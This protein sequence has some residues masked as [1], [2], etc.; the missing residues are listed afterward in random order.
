MKHSTVSSPDFF[1]PSPNTTS[2]SNAPAAALALRTAAVTA[3]FAAVVTL[4]ALAP[5][6]GQS[7]FDRTEGRTSSGSGLSV[8]VFADIEDAQLQKNR[9]TTYE[10][11]D[12]TRTTVYVPIENPVDYLGTQGSHRKMADTAYLANG[13]VSPQHTFFNNTLYVSNDPEA[14]NTLLITVDSSSIADPGGDCAIAEVR[15]GRAGETIT[16]QVPLTSA[17]GPTNGPMATYYQAFVRVLDSRA[18]NDDGTPKYALSDG[19]GCV[20]D[21]ND[22]DDV[23]FDVAT[24]IAQDETAS[25]LARHND[26]VTVSMSGAGTVSVRVDGEGPELLDVTPEDLGYYRSRDLEY[27]FTVRDD[28]AGLRHDGELVVTLDGDYTQA[29]RDDDHT[30]SGEPLSMPSGSQVSVNGNAAEIDVMVWAKDAHVDTAED[31]THTG[32]WT[33]LGSRPGVA[34][35]FSADGGSMDEGP[36]YME[37]TARDRAGNTTVSDALDDDGQQPH[38]FTVDDTEPKAA[39]AWTGIAYDLEFPMG[40]KEVPDRS[41]IMVDFVE[42][43]RRDIRPEL[44]RVAGHEVVSVLQPTEVPPAERTVLGRDGANSAPAG[45]QRLTFAPPAPR[46]ATLLAPRAQSCS[47]TLDEKV[48]IGSPGF[49]YDSTSGDITISWTRLS[50]ADCHGYRLAVLTHDRA[51]LIEDLPRT[52]ESFSIPRGSE[53]GRVIEADIRDSDEEQLIIQIALRHGSVE[54]GTDNFGKRGS[55]ATVDLND[56]TAPEDALPLSAPVIAPY[57]LHPSSSPAVLPAIAEGDASLECGFTDS[58]PAWDKVSPAYIHRP[59]EVDGWTLVGYY[60]QLFYTPN[61]EFDLGRHFQYT[62]IGVDGWKTSSEFQHYYNSSPAVY[63]ARAQI[64]TVYEK[65]GRRLAGAVR[66]VWCSATSVENPQTDSTPPLL[67]TAE[68]DG[69]TLTLTYNEQLDGDSTPD[70]SAFDVQVDGTKNTVNRVSVSGRTVELTL[71]STVTDGQGVT[72]SYE[73]P[74]SNPIQ[75]AAGND[76]TDFLLYPV[77]EALVS[78]LSIGS[79]NGDGNTPNSDADDNEAHLKALM[80]LGYWPIDINGDLIDDVRARIY[81]QVARELRADETPEVLL[82]GGG[83]HDLAGN[84]NPSQNVPTRD[85]IAPRFTITVTATAQD[86][87]VANHLGEFVVDVRA[88][89]DLRRR[90]EV[91][92]TG[93]DTTTV[94]RSG[95]EAYDYSI[96]NIERGGTLVVQDGPQHWSRTYAVASLSGLD[97][98]FGLV[99]Y[100]YDYEGNIGESGGWEAVR[101]QRKP[102]VVTTPALNDK[103]DLGEM[104]DAGALLEIDRR[105]NGGIEPE[106][107]MTPHQ[108]EKPHDTESVRPYVHLN[109]HGEAMEYAVCPTDGCGAANDNPDAKF[110]DSHANVNVTEIMLD[111]GSMMARL[112]RVGPMEFAFQTEELELGRHEVAYKAVDDAGNEFSG[113]YAFTVVERLPYELELTAGWNLI[114]VPGTPEDPSLDT[115]LPPE[116]R[117]SPVLSYQDGDWVAATRSEDGGWRG[118]LTSIEAGYGYWVFAQTF[119]TISTL[120]PEYD[121]ASIPPSVEV[122]FG[123]NLV[124][125]IDLFQNPAGVAPGAYGGGSGEADEYFKSIP[126]QVSYTYDTLQSRWVRTTEGDGDAI[127]DVE[128]DD[129]PPE[130]VTGKGYWVWSLEPAT[131]VP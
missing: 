81:V 124:G 71:S 95:D 53:L 99:V 3:A 38:L 123:W 49:S 97:E 21:P 58:D 17:T 117:V 32:R 82:F 85:G 28:D 92:F 113:D 6:F 127:S 51:L 16:V 91:H 74:S 1:N 59:A 107:S 14:Y 90:P 48:R 80:M 27:A 100:G 40:G 104:D 88:D 55:S 44:V 121:P 101:H 4:L 39:E 72:L 15:N 33:L 31:V 69:A 54:A 10:E 119:E 25:I 65:N 20:D 60:R 108:F 11:E 67:Q 2:P 35:A 87:P 96:L 50:T 70:G 46:A 12:G 102:D 47:D 43:L 111:D 112:S 116:R 63:S 93:I 76:A 115:V 79:N 8:G 84:P 128:G 61:E 23:S 78:A 29:N 83:V 105:F 45:P 89:E 56:L 125:V 130:I 26:V 129:D 75:D 68:V 42:P 122:N 5:V 37:I 9:E 19:P 62:A 52:D 103:L 109:F 36:Y 118:N 106:L 18:E 22:P 98:L 66:T 41:W 131:L 13:R 73:A 120:I 86:R 34:Y 64:V 126:W 30:T 24:G 110:F 57:L 94:R 114:S 77:A 7:T